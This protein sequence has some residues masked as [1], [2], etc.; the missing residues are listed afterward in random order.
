MDTA[1]VQLATPWCPECRTSLHYDH[2]ATTW[3][4][5]ECGYQTT[6]ESLVH[7]Q[8]MD[9]TPKPIYRH[10]RADGWPYCP[11]CDEDELWS[12]ATYATE[13]IIVGCYR[14]GWKP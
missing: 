5:A 12:D 2:E 3:D 4:C 14:C 11:R 9:M 6:I 13:D 7:R 10:R 1:T 8:T